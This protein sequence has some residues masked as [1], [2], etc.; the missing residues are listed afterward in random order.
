MSSSEASNETQTS[1]PELLVLVMRGD[2]SALERLYQR[3][4]KIVFSVA[5]RVCR[6]IATAEDILQEIFMQIWRSPEQFANVTG[7]LHGW[8]AVTARNRSLDVL[9]RRRPMEHV[10]TLM[11]ASSYDLADRAE[12]NL[13]MQKVGLLLHLLPEEQQEALQMSFFDGKTHAEISEDTGC[14]LGTI[15]TRIRSG[16]KLLRMEFSLARPG[17]QS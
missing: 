7:S 13:M 12:T 17:L 1:D 16:L 14:P 9:R 4:S 5:L 15:K 2:E 6:E 3:H 10:D 8:L 11:L